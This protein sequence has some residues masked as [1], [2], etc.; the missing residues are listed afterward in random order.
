MNIPNARIAELHQVYEASTGLHLPLNKAFAR[1]YQWS[2]W[3]AEGYTVDD[4]KLVVA[5]LKRSYREY[6][7]KMCRFSSLI[8]DLERFSEWLAEARATA[9]NTR[10]APTPR[11]QILAAT[12]RTEEAPQATEKRVDKIAGEVLAKGWEQ[13]KRDANL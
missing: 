5:H 2:L 11:Q 10:P 4:L 8:G 7:V 1:E 12:G 6:A 3:L 9:R 13:L